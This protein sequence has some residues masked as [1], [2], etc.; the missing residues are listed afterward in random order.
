MTKWY[1]SGNALLIG[2]GFRV[3]G[4]F[5]LEGLGFRVWGLGYFKF[6]VLRLVSEEIKS[7]NI[8]RI[9]MTVPVPGRGPRQPGVTN[10]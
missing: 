2:L 8:K 10:Q 7:G 3:K 1:K 6:L 5:L 4:K 9:N